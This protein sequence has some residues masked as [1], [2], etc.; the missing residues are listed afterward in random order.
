[1]LE[2]VGLDDAR[3]LADFGELAHEWLTH[4]RTRKRD[5][6]DADVAQRLHPALHERLVDCQRQHGQHD[7]GCQ[8]ADFERSTR[9]AGE[10][11]HHEGRDRDGQR[12]QHG[13]QERDV[14]YENPVDNPGRE[15]DEG[16]HGESV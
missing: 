14:A 7:K 9:P 10:S 12:D 2:Q 1:M 4:Q 16:T 6:E 13:G 3:R 8:G 15:R 5:E 11:P